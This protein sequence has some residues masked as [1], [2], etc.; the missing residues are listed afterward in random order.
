MNKFL[1][2]FIDE[3]L[4]AWERF[5]NAK[6]FMILVESWGVGSAYRQLLFAREVYAEITSR[7]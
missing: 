3:Y 6:G 5:R 7:R 1:E 2:P 4:L